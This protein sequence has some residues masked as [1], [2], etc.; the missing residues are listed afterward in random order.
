MVLQLF[1][2][3]AQNKGK[4]RVM[5]KEMLIVLTG[6]K[7]GYDCWKVCS[8]QEM[9][10]HHAFD[11]KVE[12]VATKGLRVDPRS[13]HA[14]LRFAQTERYRVACFSRQCDRIDRR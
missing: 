2:V 7:P 14:A 4:P 10:E 5:A 1:L 9:E 8:N 6:L 13:Y 3:F 11:A 12:L